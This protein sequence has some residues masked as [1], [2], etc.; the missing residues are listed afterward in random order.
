M[1]IG[2]LAK[3]TGCR[4]V[5]IRYYEKEGLLPAPE[6][7]DGNYRIYGQDA[8]ERLEFIMHCRKHGIML[9]DVKKLL[10]FRDQPQGDCTWVTELLNGHIG[11]LELQIESL[12]DLKSHLEQ[13]RSRCAGG[14]DGDACGIM[15]SLEHR[16]LCCEQDSPKASPKRVK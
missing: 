10:D 3:R 4:V 5:T 12:E 9:P 15:Q 1:K 13:L 6:R 16:E 11:D 7:S 8:L 14:Q 2:E